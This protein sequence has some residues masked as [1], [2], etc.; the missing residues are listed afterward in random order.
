MIGH[1]D[2]SP[3]GR[4]AID[5]SRVEAIMEDDVGYVTIVTHTDT[6]RVKGGYEHALK[7]WI[8]S[9]EEYER[10]RKAK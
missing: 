5:M 8:A 1:F 2:V 10:S 6:F 3:K 4:V 7:T 9:E